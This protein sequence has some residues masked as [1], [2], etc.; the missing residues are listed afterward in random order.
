M[1]NTAQ[2][3]EAGLVRLEE[4]LGSE[5]RPQECMVLDE[6]DGFLTALVCTPDDVPAGEWLA[7]VWGGEN[8][9]FADECEERDIVELIFALR[10]S[11][12]EELRDSDVFEPMWYVGLDDEDNEVVEPEGWCSGFMRATQ[13]RS[14]YWDRLFESDEQYL[15]LAPIIAFAVY[16]LPESAEDPMLAQLGSD[17]SLRDEFINAIP[18]AVQD[19][20]RSRA[21]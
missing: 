21:V 14:A 6:L 15:W 10:R 9:G 7:E 1:N 13:L 3:D 16:Q 18:P 17:Q 19:I 2:L 8:P 5:Q 4:F 12:E 20:Y 11:I